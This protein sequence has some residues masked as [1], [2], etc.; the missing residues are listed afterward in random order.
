MTL[1][2]VFSSGQIGNLTLK[3]RFVLAPMGS[4][5]AVQEMITEPFIDYHVLRAKGGVGLNIVEY[6][7][8][9]PTTRN[10]TIPSLY[11]DSFIAGM[12]KLTTAVHDAGGKI[13]V[14]LWHAGRQTSSRITGQPIIAPSMIPSTVYKEMPT[15]M[16]QEM[17]Q[18]IIL[19]FADAALRAKKAGFDMIELHGASGYLLNQFMSPY[20]NTR[21]DEY[22]GNLRNRT[23]FAVE[24]IKKIKQTVGNDFPLSY[25]ITINEFV[26]GGLLPEDII[27][28]SP[29][30]EEAGVDIIHVTS[31]LLETLHQTIAPLEKPAGFNAEFSE[32]IKQVVRIPVMVVGRINDPVIAEH[33]ISSGQADFVALGRTLIAD[34]AFCVK[35][36]EGR[37]DD[38]IK[39]IGCNQSCISGQRPDPEAG[40]N[41]GPVCM[42]NPITGREYL[43]HDEPAVKSKRILV[44]GGG[45]AGMTAATR[46]QQRGHHVTLCEKSSGL[47][48]QFY[49]AGQAPSKKEMAD[50]AQ[51][52]GRAMMRSGVEVLLNTEA[53]SSMIDSF[54]PDEVVI[55]TGSI[56]F[57]PNIPGNK[58]G[59]VKSAHD[60]LRGGVTGDRVA[61]IGGGLVGIEVA[62]LM[63]SQ[64]KQPLIIEMLDEVA[65]ELVSSRK[66]Y[67]QQ[68]LANHKIPVYVQTKCVA[69]GE[70]DIT[71]EQAEHRF[72]LNE[73][74][75]VVLA[76]GSKSLNHLSSLMEQKG[77]PFHIIGDALKPRKA[78]EAIYEGAKISQ[79]I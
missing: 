77:I 4:G 1:H 24:V 40:H 9:H 19:A 14:Q 58:L 67:A 42:R 65:K 41:Y 10:A 76:T 73:V 45:A 70:T 52:M 36:E 25:R 51:Q 7:A 50:S 49:L 22:G 33:I 16:N 71:L 68:F 47:G 5:M 26:P 63:V 15:E 72:K 23:R 31:G 60:V 12:Q 38:I 69:I 57:I 54:Q 61:I 8:V 46:L 66:I 11:N 13:G 2:H 43:F 20:S 35:A 79:T 18:E 21:N 29:L 44:I 59:H 75:T 32:R 3:N 27:E 55:A 78:L 28:I 48:G 30:L 37:F 17:I 34:P 56:P 62:E 74:D 64:G 6:T 39:C 53:D